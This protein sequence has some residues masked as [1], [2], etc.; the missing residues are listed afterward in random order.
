MPERPP[1]KSAVQRAL[2]LLDEIR[3]HSWV[4]EF[5]TGQSATTV[6]IVAAD[7][8][9]PAI[10]ADIIEWLLFKRF[11]TICGRNLRLPALEGTTFTQFDDTLL[12]RHCHDAFPTDD[13]QA[14]IFEHNS[15]Y[16][17]RAASCN[18]HLRQLRRIDTDRLD[19][20]ATGS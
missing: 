9:Q 16:Q 6:H 5:V 4:I 7:V 10:P 13:D 2:R 1:P 12:C 18:E 15:D 3:D 11:R 20:L 8:D 14:L 19:Q 17:Q